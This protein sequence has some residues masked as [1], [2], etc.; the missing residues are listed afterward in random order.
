MAKEIC[1][2][3]FIKGVATTGLVLA[4]TATLGGCSSSSPSS[5]KWDE[6]TDVV[7]VG[8]GFAGLAAAIEAKTAGTD[9][10]ILEKMDMAGGNSVINGGGLN[11]YDSPQ[12]RKLGIKD[13]P[14]LMLEDTLKS[15]LYFNDVEQAKLVV[16]KSAEAGDW[17]INY[18]G[19]KFL[20]DKLMQDGGLSVPRSLQTESFSGASIVNPMLDKLKEM[21]VKVETN[22]RMSKLIQDENR[23]VI[24]VEVIDNYRFNSDSGSG[25]KFIKAKKAVILAG[26]GFS[27]SIPFRSTQDPRLNDK[28]EH[29][30]QLGATGDSMIEGMRIGAMPIQLD[31]IQLGPWGCPDE[32]GFGFVPVFV[33]DAGIKGIY[34]NPTTGKRFVS[35]TGDRKV[36]ADAMLAQGAPCLLLLDSVGIGKVA[37]DLVDRILNKTLFTYNS[38]E[39]LASQY[40]IPIDALKE[41]VAR[42]NSFVASGVDPDFGKQNIKECSPIEKPP[43]YAVKLYP[44]VHH[45]MGGIQKNLDM[46]VIDLDGNVIPGLYAAGE[47]TYGM[48]GACRLGGNG[49]LDALV[50]GRIAGQKTAQETPVA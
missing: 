34:I 8:S 49:T 35:E 37:K 45:C 47:I 10:R 22:Q 27:A 41:T 32:K 23:R 44:K 12:H 42:Y 50:C 9:V 21:G 2:R 5:I 48:H 25:T 40:N 29:T 31:Q 1:R 19:V 36:R 24:G 13:S 20:Q 30:N 4:G 6:E 18:L 26:G 3:D 43:F 15:G 14:E 28:L 16:D 33:V 17:C 11:V 7:I 38:L 46:Q 39:E